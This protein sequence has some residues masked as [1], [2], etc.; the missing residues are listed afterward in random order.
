M[1][2]QEKERKQNK[3]VTILTLSEERKPSETQKQQILKKGAQYICR[4]GLDN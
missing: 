2:H 3:L 4:A 1:I